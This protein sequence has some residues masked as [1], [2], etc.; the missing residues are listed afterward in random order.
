MKFDPKLLAEVGQSLIDF[1]VYASKYVAKDL[2]AQT[3]RENEQWEAFINSPVGAPSP[4]VPDFSKME[5]WHAEAAKKTHGFMAE[6]PPVKE[7]P[8]H[9]VGATFSMVKAGLKPLDDELIEVNT[10]VC[11]RLR[12]GESFKVLPDRRVR[13]AMLTVKQVMRDGMGVHLG[14]FCHDYEGRLH[15]LAALEVRR[16]SA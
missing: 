9:P 6:K 10:L 14:Y 8:R 13:D 11:R 1:S 3:A 15:F 16:F 12:T 7:N 5:A 4:D 2:E